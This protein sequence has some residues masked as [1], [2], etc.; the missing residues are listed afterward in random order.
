[1]IDCKIKWKRNVLK[2][3]DV[4]SQSQTKHALNGLRELLTSSALYLYLLINPSI[5]IWIYLQN[6]MSHWINGT[7]IQCRSVDDDDDYAY[8]YLIFHVCTF[9]SDGQM[10]AVVVGF[11]LLL[12][13]SFLVFISFNG[14][15]VCIQLHRS[16]Q[17]LFVRVYF[18][19]ILWSQK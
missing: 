19:C 1:M 17:L 7:C 16:D 15:Q 14:K 18:V 11:F 4:K 5:C 2:I 8:K 13:N 6:C 9:D 12:I 3:G 10:I